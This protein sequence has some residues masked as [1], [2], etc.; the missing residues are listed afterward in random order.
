MRVDQAIE[1]ASRFHEGAVDKAGRPYIGHI[2]RVV[3]AVDSH[4]EKL[5]AAMHDLLEDTPLTSGHLSCA[6][7]PPGTILAVEALTRASGEGYE[8]FCQRAASHPV[9]RVVKLADVA[10]NADEGRLELLEPEEA[11]RLRSKYQRARS[12]LSQAPE[13]RPEKTQREYEA[14]F[15]TIGIP[16]EIGESWSTFWCGECGLPAGTLT[17]VF[18]EVPDSLGGPVGY[19]LVLNTFLG[20]MAPP[21]DDDEVEHVQ[22]LLENGD[23]QSFYDRDPELA[24]FWCPRCRVSYCNDHW[25]QVTKLDEG[26]YDEVIGMCPHG[27]RRQLSD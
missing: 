5:A 1:L 24:P 4:E 18:S 9:A 6:G 2:L 27:H 23:A 15:A 16:Q 14:E 17:L 10:D 12:I 3:N 21:T 26:F 13:A 25:Q 19:R 7:S 8:E 22:A 20:S 11:A